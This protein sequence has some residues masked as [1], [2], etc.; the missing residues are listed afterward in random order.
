M[1]NNSQGARHHA[2]KM[3]ASKVRQARKSYLTGKYTQRA[4]AQK[5]GIADA[6]MSA[7]LKGTSW[8]HLV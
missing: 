8:K 2:S 1:P 3:T 7:I 6:S 4:L 5:Y